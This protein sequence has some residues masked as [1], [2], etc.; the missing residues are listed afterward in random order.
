MP[1]RGGAPGDSEGSGAQP[2]MDGQL[3][4]TATAGCAG[5]VANSARCSLGSRRVDNVG[6]ASVELAKGVLRHSDQ[7]HVLDPPDVKTSL[8]GC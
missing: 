1:E 5:R 4:P 8:V 2:E 7:L 6:V 3:K